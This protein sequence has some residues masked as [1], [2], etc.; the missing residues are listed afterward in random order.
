[1]GLHDGV[2]AVLLRYAIPAGG[3]PATNILY[4]LGGDDALAADLRSMEAQ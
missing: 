3:Q 2:K 1:M 4:K